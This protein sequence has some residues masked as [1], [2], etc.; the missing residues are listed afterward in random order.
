M[1]EDCE[2][3]G[4]PLGNEG[5]LTHVVCDEEFMERHRNGICPQCNKELPNGLPYSECPDCDA[6]SPYLDYPGPQ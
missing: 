1:A 3:C 5:P 6:D 2:H 4:K